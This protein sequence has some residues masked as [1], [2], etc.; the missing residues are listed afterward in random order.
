[1]PPPGKSS[2]LFLSYA[3]D[4]ADLVRALEQAIEVRGWS[5]WVDRVS[6]PSA[7]EW[8]AEIRRGIESA[9]GF[10]FVLTPSS[11]AS[12]MCRV[13]LSIAVDLSKRLLPLWPLTK[14]AW[15]DAQRQVRARVG[16]DAVGEVP[17]ELQKLDYI[18]INDFTGRD[19]ALEALVDEL[20]KAASRDLEWLR[21]HTRLQQDVKRWLDGRYATAALLR[22]PLLDAAETMLSATGKEPPLTALQREFVEASQAERVNALTREAAQLAHRVLDLPDER[23]AVGVMVSLEGLA[24][25]LHT[26]PLEGALRT[27]V[28]GWPLAKASLT[29]SRPFLRRAS[30]TMVP[31]SAWKSGARD[32]T[33][34]IECFS[35]SN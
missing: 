28:S 17:P 15:D 27:I 5:T 18:D 34:D 30:T 4:D 6:I 20:L 24:G 26:P 21:Q 16:A 9:D 3:R 14:T 1:M 12:R 10:V 2:H 33:I 29:I 13:E 23:V 11:V 32:G 7:S 8:M 35:K 31:G 22:G 25:Y 19:D